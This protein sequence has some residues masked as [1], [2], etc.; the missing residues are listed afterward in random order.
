MLKEH[1]TVAL[2]RDEP[3]QGLKA[4]DIG[5]IVHVYKDNSAYEVEFV[6]LRGKTL[7][8]LTLPPDAVRAIADREI[9]HA[10]AVA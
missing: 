8:L 5:A 9:A 10:R 2:A 3:S 7:A 4:G 6:S 1:D